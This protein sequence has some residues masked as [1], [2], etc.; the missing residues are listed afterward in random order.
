LELVSTA[1]SID[2]FAA[3]ALSPQRLTYWSQQ[4]ISTFEAITPT[5]S[6][7]EQ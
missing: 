5:V 4:P 3:G 1:S 2:D 7:T 6:F